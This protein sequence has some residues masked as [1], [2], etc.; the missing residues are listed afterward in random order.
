MDNYARALEYARGLFLKWDQEKMIAR[1]RLRHDADYLYLN[2]LGD[3]WRIG[4]SD[5]T[6]ACIAGEA[7][8]GNYS[9]AL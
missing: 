5:G 2:F 1:C 9:Q 8:E 4:R 3:S 6:A 7:A